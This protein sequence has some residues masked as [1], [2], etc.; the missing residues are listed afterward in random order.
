MIDMGGVPMIAFM[1]PASGGVVARAYN[2]TT[3]VD[4]GK[5]SATTGTQINMGYDMSN[6]RIYAVYL[7]AAQSYE[8]TLKVHNGIMRSSI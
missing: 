7:D 8:A 5:V 4:K 2:G 1:S 3:F 6:G